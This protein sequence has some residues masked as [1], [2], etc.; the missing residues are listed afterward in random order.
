MAAAIILILAG[1][2]QA[3]PLGNSFYGIFNKFFG[4]GYYLLPT[5]SFILGFSFMAPERKGSSD[6]PLSEVSC[7]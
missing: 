4:W 2:G 5:V 1:A 6:S 3:G 7:S